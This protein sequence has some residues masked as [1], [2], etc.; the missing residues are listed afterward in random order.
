MIYIADTNTLIDFPEV[1]DEYHVL[2]PSHVNREIENLELTRKSDR[3]LQWKIRR[4][5]NKIDENDNAYVNIKDY[6]FTLDDD[7]DP[8]YTDNIILQI[9]HDEGYGVI[10]NDR[11]LRRKCKQFG[12][13]FINPNVSTFVEHKGFK[14]D[15]M[16]ESELEKIYNNWVENTYNLLVNE[17]LVIYDDAVTDNLE[18]LDIFKWNGKYMET[19]KRNKRSGKIDLSFKTSQFDKFVPKDAYQMMAV[20]SIL[21]NQLTQIRGRAGSGKSKIALETSWHLIERGEYERLVVFVN[22]T[23]VRDSQEMGFYKG[24]KLEKLMQSSVGVMLKSKFGDEIEI[25][26]QIIQGRLDILPFVDLRGYETGEKKTIVWMTESQN[27]T[28][29]LMKLGLQRISEN[30]KVIIDGDYHAQVD[31]DVYA[32]SN[33][34]KRVS[35]IFRGEDLYGEVELQNIYRS[36]VADIADRM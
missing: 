19:L 10:T 33:G 24:D 6:K 25:E 20:D 14:E 31:K 13:E 17:Y 7:L 21:N 23:P 5:K 28:A 35:E 11:L 8:T 18:I 9:A 26:R 15:F 2:I 34:M 30:T 22:P 3:T 32:T 4:F 27:L 12:I 36:R 16:V 1:L 29:D